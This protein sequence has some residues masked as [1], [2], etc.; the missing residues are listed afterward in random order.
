MRDDLD[1]LVRQYASAYNLPPSLLKAQVMVESSGD[2]NA[3][4]YE[5]G[6]FTAYVKGNQKARA[7]AYGPFAACSV[8]LM[9]IMVEVAYETGYAGRPEGLFNASTGL[10]WG[11]KKM[12]SLLHASGG[13]Y[14]TALAA[15]NGGAALIPHPPESWPVGVQLYVSKVYALASTYET[16]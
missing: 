3:L 5:P 16:P 1:L 11:C 7:W 4:R 9:Q 6:F 13:V 8:G 14:R 12:Q 10:L 15:Y 2:P